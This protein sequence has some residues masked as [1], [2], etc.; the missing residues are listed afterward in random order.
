M[1]DASRDS[2]EL[3]EVLYLLHTHIADHASNDLSLNQ[4]RQTLLQTLRGRLTRHTALTRALRELEMQRILMGKG[5]GV[6]IS[7]PELVNGKDK[8]NQEDEEDAFGGRKRKVK[9]AGTSVY[10]VL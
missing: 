9:A 8:Q 3:V 6:K 5:A 4:S 7:G 1:G 10:R 2:Q